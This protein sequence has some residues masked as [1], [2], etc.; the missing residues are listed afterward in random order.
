LN[1]KKLIR[2]FKYSYQAKIIS[3]ILAVFL[4]IH[5]T[6][7]NIEEQTFKVPLEL[8]GIP[9]SFVVVNDIPDF[10]EITINEKRARLIKL[11]F[12]G[13]IKGVVELPAVRKGWVNIPLSSNIIEISEDISRRNLSVDNPKFI[14][15]NLQRVL[16]KDVPVRLAYN[17][18]IAKNRFIAGDPVIIPEKVSVRGASTI[19]EK[20]HFLSTN[21]IDIRNRTGI[22][23]ELVDLRTR[24]YEITVEPEKV[25]V[26]L[27]IC[28]LRSRKLANIPPTILMD[29]RNLE[30]KC[31][32]P[33]ASITVE[34]REEFIDEIV[35]SDISIILNINSVTTG[36]YTV[37]PEVIVPD[38]I[39]RYQLDVDTF[40]VTVLPDSTAPGR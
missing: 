29:N 7:Q 33:A 13:N 3:V 36:T 12:F 1:T 11:R 4:W 17:G 18:E 31:S 16:T 10:V 5:V 14:E 19:V 25:L 39:L 20:I 8:A 34:G 27:E 37:K 40:S 22:I 24:D 2:L 30:I 23:K 15:L 9:D 26:E 38:R 28:K 6:A 35:P 32:P 21:E